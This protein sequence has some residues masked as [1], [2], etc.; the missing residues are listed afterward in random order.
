VQRDVL[1]GGAAGPQLPQHQAELA[2]TQESV[3]VGEG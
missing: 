2:S 1:G 3:H